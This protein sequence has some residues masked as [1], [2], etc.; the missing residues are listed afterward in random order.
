[1]SDYD[2]PTTTVFNDVFDETKGLYVYCSPVSPAVNITVQFPDDGTSLG[3]ILSEED[4][5]RLVDLLK[6]NLRSK[7]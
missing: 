2:I 1:M 6:A 4:V 3:V 7:K 5:A